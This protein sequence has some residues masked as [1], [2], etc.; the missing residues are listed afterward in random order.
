MTKKWQSQQRLL[1]DGATCVMNLA[2]KEQIAL[3]R[4]REYRADTVEEAMEME[5][6]ETNVVVVVVEA[7][8][9]IVLV[10]QR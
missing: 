6:T 7:I 4:R 8:Q 9:A 10:T 1:S 3:T 5:E 2:T